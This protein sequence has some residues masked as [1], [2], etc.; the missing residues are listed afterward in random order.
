MGAL[1]RRRIE[2]E[3]GW[4]HQGASYLSVY[5]RMFGLPPQPD[6]HAAVLAAGD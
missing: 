3:L 4:S 5:E 2:E 6:E 1:G